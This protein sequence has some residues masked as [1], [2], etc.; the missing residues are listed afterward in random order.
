[1]TTNRYRRR[2][3]RRRPGSGSRRGTARRAA[4]RAPRR[5]GSRA[6]GTARCAPCPSCVIDQH[7]EPEDERRDEVERDRFAHYE[8]QHLHDAGHHQVGDRQR[9]QHLPPE[10][11]QLVVAVARQR[12]ADPDE[13][14]EEDE[15]LDQEPGPARDEVEERAAPRRSGTAAASRRGTASSPPTRRRSCWRI[16]RGRTARS[17]CRCTRCGSR[18]SAPAPLP[19]GRTARGWSRPG[20][21]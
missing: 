21:R 7:G 18:R 20:R 8:Q 19:A 16:R 10:P 9:D 14:V 5:T 15:R 17:A 13:D 6:P 12:R 11:H 4:R 1:M 3:R 2:C